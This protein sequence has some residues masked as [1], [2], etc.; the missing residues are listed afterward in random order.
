MEKKPS[1]SRREL[2]A[3]VMQALYANEMSGDPIAH[4]RSTILPEVED[5]SPEYTYASRMLNRLIGD[6]SEVTALLE[7]H[8][9]NWDRERVAVIDR[10]LIQ[11]GIAEFLFFPD[12]PPKVTINEM[13]E[14][15][16][17]YSTE[18]SGL[19]VNGILDAIRNDLVTEGRINKTGRGLVNS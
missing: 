8:L 11:M 1:M 2:R 14:I 12:I 4:L 5:D 15:A 9:K 18:K 10:I 17:E 13:I 7:S 3:K 19:F 16:K 6:P